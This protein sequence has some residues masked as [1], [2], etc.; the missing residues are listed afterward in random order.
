MP[1]KEAKAAKQ[2]MLGILLRISVLCCAVLAEVL[3]R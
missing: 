2:R 1:T 3:E